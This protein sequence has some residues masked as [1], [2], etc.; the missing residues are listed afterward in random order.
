MHV[1]S[2]YTGKERDAETGLD[3][4]GARYF[5]G[6]QGRFTSPDPIWIT[7]ERL[8]DPQ[9]LD[10]YAYGRNNPFRYVDRDGMDVTLGK[11]GLGGE[12]ECFERVQEQLQQVDRAHV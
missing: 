1:T 3:Y 4:F 6:P 10:L 12:Q 11:C 9:R 5:S 8:L 7:K 2:E